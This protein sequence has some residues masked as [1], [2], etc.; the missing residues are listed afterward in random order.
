VTGTGPDSRL[1]CFRTSPAI[2]WFETAV[3]QTRSGKCWNVATAAILMQKLSKCTSKY[4]FLMSYTKF[5]KISKT[6]LQEQVF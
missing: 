1:Q 2:G 5:K 6:F 4:N 3:K